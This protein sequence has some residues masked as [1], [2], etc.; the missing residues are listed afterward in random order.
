[1]FDRRDDC[2]CT[3]SIEGGALCVDGS[4]C[5]GDALCV[6][7]SD[8]DGDGDLVANEGCR[9]TVVAACRDRTV[10]AV[11]V[12]A[13]GFERRYGDRAVALFVAAGRFLARLGDASDPLAERVRRDPLGA[14][15][16]ARARAPPVSEWAAESGLLVAAEGIA[17]YDA[18]AVHEGP[19][20]APVRVR[21]T[22]P[23]DWTAEETRSLSTGGVATRYR[24]DRGRP[25]YHLRPAWASLDDAGRD[26]FRRAYERV[27]AGDYGG[28]AR[29]RRRAVDAVTDGDADSDPDSDRNSRVVDVLRRQTAGDGVLEDAFADPAVTDVYAPSDDDGPALRVGLG[30]DG[31][32][33]TNCR[34]TVDGASALASRVRAESGRAFSRAT[35]T[36]DAATTVGE[37]PVRVAGVRDPV[38][39]GVGFAF[40]RGGEDAFTL[41][42]LVANDT[43]PAEAA[44]LLSLA[45]T[46]A[47]ATLVAGARGAGKT[48]L[49]GALCFELDAT[50]RAVLV[51]D[52]PE[53]PVEALR[54]DDRD[55]QG[56]Q[57]SERGD[58]LS[59]AD[60]LRTALRLGE[61]ALVVGEVRGEEAQVL[62]E[63]MRVGA[64]SDAVLGTIHGDGARAVRERVVEDLGVSASSFAATD[65]VVT[66]RR[67]TVD[68]SVERRVARIEEV[69]GAGDDATFRSLY[70]LDDDGR[71]RA[72]SRIA[73]GNSALV[74]DLATPTEDYA[75]VRDALADREALLA[76]RAR[77]G[78]LDPGAW[79]A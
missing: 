9:A 25:R 63:A 19:V 17:G 54:A 47:A 24:D 59:A 42:A 32:V 11:R 58:A 77:A 34:V 64:S 35:P 60:A 5:D 53:L 55:V 75:A 23:A 62:Y 28:T 70:E 30:E 18:L 76:D 43:V 52:T 10:D 2:A 41:P 79:S 48:T 8:C 68:G 72:T 27:A 61:G 69:V 16:S 20:V 12:R 40:R 44:A 51:E 31:S 15:E 71:L 78:R 56:L 67:V 57:T 65:C 36:V 33:P 6:D 66:C 3:T 74:A 37:T 39:D 13:R 14:A 50:T 46:R 22:P 26:A 73:R 29:A 1:M 49:L 21:L 45:T 38:A 7:G 4:D